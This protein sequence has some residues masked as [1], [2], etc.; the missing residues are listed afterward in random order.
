M[1]NLR[2]RLPPLGSLAAFE[3]ACRHGSFTRA[4]EE[5]NLTQA[6][7]S[8]QIRALEDD[9]AV[10]LFERRRHD[11]ALTA[12]GQRFA[13]VVNPA[14]LQIATAKGALQRDANEFT[15]CT[16]LCLAAHWLMP[17][18]S[19]F[20]ADHPNLCLRILTSPDPL[21][22]GSADAD[23]ILTY[24]SSKSG[25]LVVAHQFEEQIVP[26]CSPLFRRT[27][28]RRLTAKDIA[29]ATLVDFRDDEGR[30]MDW[31]QFLS[32]HGIASVSRAGLSFSTYNSA[33]D[34]ATQG[35]GLVLGWTHSADQLLRDGRLV[36]LRE[37]SISSPDPLCA[38]L[39]HASS[40]ALHVL[41]WICLEIKATSQ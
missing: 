41:E 5:L 11:V 38:N 30:W 3:A 24:G 21:R 26:L 25:K 15:I 13:E 35:L 39:Q 6:A 28:P 18:L 36:A 22:D 33:L 2:N 16:E 9:L 32:K 7:V 31:R 1:P 40:M 4:A 23:L 37:L 17:R 34:A 14:V 20:Q 27:L 8:R 19:R 29:T 12:A 10:M